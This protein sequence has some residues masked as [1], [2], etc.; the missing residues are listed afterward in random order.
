MRRSGLDKSLVIGM[1]LK[2]NTRTL[3]ARTALT[4]ISISRKAVRTF[5][6]VSWRLF[7]RVGRSFSIRGWLSALSR[8]MLRHLG[9]HHK[10]QG[11]N[12]PSTVEIPVMVVCSAEPD[13]FIWHHSI[14]GKNGTIF[15]FLSSSQFVTHSNI[16]K[17]ETAFPTLKTEQRTSGEL[18]SAASSVTSFFRK[19][20]TIVGGSSSQHLARIL[21]TPRVALERTLG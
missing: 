6:E 8:T 18:A 19:S 16:R 14:F 4:L 17:R 7:F 9:K 13:A 15:S 3:A 21:Q 2:K 10:P 11:I 5:S 20:V 1:K 12:I